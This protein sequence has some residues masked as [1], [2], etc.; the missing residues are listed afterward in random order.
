MAAP[1]VLVWQQVS[2]EKTHL[3]LGT[4]LQGGGGE[5]DERPP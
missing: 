4:Q 1:D 5:V 2:V 3:L